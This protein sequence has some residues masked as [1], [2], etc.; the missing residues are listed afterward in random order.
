MF[1]IRSNGHQLIATHYL[2]GR[3]G[4]L[5]KPVLIIYANAIRHP[6]ETDLLL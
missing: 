2:L 6:H 3:H 4:P 1:Q 5:M